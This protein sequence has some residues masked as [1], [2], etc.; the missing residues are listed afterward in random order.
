[1]EEI[2]S[3]E[4]NGDHVVDVRRLRIRMLLLKLELKNIKLFGQKERN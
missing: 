4:S 2:D 1:M 3:E